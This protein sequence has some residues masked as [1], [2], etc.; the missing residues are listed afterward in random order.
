MDTTQIIAM[1]GSTI[2]AVFASTGFWNWLSSR[3][4]ARSSAD[5]MLLALGHDKVYYL[6]KK[7]LKEGE[8]SH[9]DY[10]TLHHIYTAYKE[11][12]GNGTAEKLYQ[13]VEHIPLVDK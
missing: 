4:K 2:G 3:G 9:D 11:L 1:I 10:D 8:I 12:G 13:E 5:K 6:C 7:Y